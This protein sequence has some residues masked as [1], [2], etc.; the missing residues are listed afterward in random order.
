M[1]NMSRP[2][3]ALAITILALAAQFH[4]HAKCRPPIPDGGGP[5]PS[6]PN[7][8]GTV[9]SKDAT[10]MLVKRAH[11]GVVRKV[12]FPPSLV[13]YSAFGGDDRVENMHWVFLPESG[14]STV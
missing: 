5:L 11:D 14:T 10:S 7:F 9:V 4:A 6:R 2:R 8:V 3:R 1:K 12:Y 13:L